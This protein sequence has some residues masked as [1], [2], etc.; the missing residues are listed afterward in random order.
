MNPKK[1]QGFGPAV[2]SAQVIDQAM[3]KLSAGVIRDIEKLQALWATPAGRGEID[4]MLDEPRASDHPSYR[5]AYDRA[6]AKRLLAPPEAIQML[7]TMKPYIKEMLDEA[8]R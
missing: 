7:N 2:P 1:S 5:T 8:S 4:A 6:Q 3:D